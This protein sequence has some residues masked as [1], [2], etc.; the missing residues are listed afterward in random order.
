MAVKKT[1]KSTTPKVSATKKSPR[2][3]SRETVKK[4][5]AKKEM[6][7]A[8]PAP[9]APREAFIAIGRRK[10][11]AA[12]VKM[13]RGDGKI[14]VNGREPQKYFTSVAQR[15]VL[16]QPLEIAGLVDRVNLAIKAK[17]GG[18]QAQAEAARL[19]IARAILLLDKERRTALKA[20]GYLR[21]DSREKERKKYGLKRARR[22]PQFSKR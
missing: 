22:A 10:S 12:R 19:G 20:A 1:K 3:A 18:L 9:A 15:R 5:T 6:V 4:E 11:A 13:E 14:T 2:K 21:R 17:G 7:R 8:V 16:K